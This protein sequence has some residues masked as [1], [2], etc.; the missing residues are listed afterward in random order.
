LKALRK[1]DEE[2]LIACSD[3]AQPALT[4]YPAKRVPISQGLAENFHISRP[5]GA[6]GPWNAEETPYMVEP[7]N[8]LGSRFY[9]SVCFVGASQ[10]GKTAA[11]GEG[12]MTH[13]V[14]NDPGD[15]LIVQMNQ[16]KAREYA[17]TRIQ[18]AIDNSPNVHKLLS[19]KA[20]DDNTHDKRFK[21]GMWL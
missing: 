2:W 17:K 9:E 7:V 21:H 6:T 11:L 14:V 10:A 19:T 18:R 5:G 15:M 20:S 13:A 12:W 3:I 16:Q 8:M 4:L 1:S